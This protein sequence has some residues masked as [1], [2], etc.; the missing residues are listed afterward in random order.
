MVFS[1]DLSGGPLLGTPARTGCRAV[2]RPAR[3]GAQTG[4]AAYQLVKRAPVAARASMFG[5][6]RSVAP[7]Q[8]RS[9]Q[10]RSS[11]RKTMTLGGRPVRVWAERAAAA[12]P[13]NCLRD[14]MGLVCTHQL[15]L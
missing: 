13:T 3:D 12:A 10:P 9:W 6:L 14:N 8:P 1:A 4:A 7:Q 2:R 11:A 15:C 5:V